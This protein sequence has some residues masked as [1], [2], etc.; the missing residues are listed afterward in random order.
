MP[1]NGGYI[2]RLNAMLHRLGKSIAL[3]D[4]VGLPPHGGKRRPQDTEKHSAGIELHC[5]AGVAFSSL[6]H[7]G[8]STP[9]RALANVQITIPD[10]LVLV[11]PH[12]GAIAKGLAV[13]ELESCGTT[14]KAV[15][16]G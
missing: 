9:K 4:E 16:A 5:Y 8:A 6:E 14:S 7:T 1:G 12:S 15:F 2:V 3:R 13:H 10:A 11:M